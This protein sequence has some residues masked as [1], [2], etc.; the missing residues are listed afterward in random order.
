[1]YNLLKNKRLILSL[2][3]FLAASLL[4]PVY[5]VPLGHA[6]PGTGLVCI[7][8]STLAT[9]C[10]TSAPTIGP[11]TAGTVFTVGVFIQGS[12]AMGGF[13]I[14]VASDNA[15]VNPTSAA[16][17]SLIASP[18]VTNICVNGLAQPGICTPNT[19]NGAGVV[20]VNTIESSGINECGGVSPCSGM[21]FTI[22]YQVV[23]LAPSTSLFFPS[24]P[25]CD[26]GQSSP[27]PTSDICV[28]VDDSFGDTLSEN[29]Q[30]ASVDQPFVCINYPSTAQS[31]P[32]G[33]PNIPVTYLST[34]T[35]G[36]FV[37]NSQSM[38]GF[39][40]YVSVDPNYLYPISAVLGTLIASP[41]FTSICINGFATNGGLCRP[42]GYSGGNGP[43]EANGPG[44]V[45]VT[46][47]ESSGSNECGGISPCSGMAIAI[48]YQVVGA[49]PHTSLS[50]PS[51]A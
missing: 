42:I 2:P 37:Q 3:L 34:F 50:Y 26:A 44:A 8:T 51:P 18:T 43:G 48:T 21:A 12:D 6:S 41:T 30:G 39:D 46:T 13:D 9:T 35:V 17:G 20:E 10:P 29:I 38:G 14:Y 28:T 15:L 36:V 25:G 1:M 23:A 32:D 11:L 16:L 5:I 7:T 27:G 47:I 33:T 22:T 40:I 19:A 4:L 31:C 49:T 45:E 24:A